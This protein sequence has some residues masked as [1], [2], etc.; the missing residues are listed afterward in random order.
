MKSIRSESLDTPFKVLAKSSII[1]ILV[2]SEG[3]DI[4]SPAKLIE[5]RINCTNFIINHV[6]QDR[7]AEEALL[8]KKIV[9]MI[10]FVPDKHLLL[11]C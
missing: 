2:D 11:L 3:V 7:P 1:F 6:D 9:N 10:Q 4:S 8:S 5:F